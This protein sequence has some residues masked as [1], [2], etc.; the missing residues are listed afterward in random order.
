MPINEFNSLLTERRIQKVIKY[1]ADKFERLIWQWDWIKNRI[2]GEYEIKN[3]VPLCPNVNC[4]NNPLKFSME[5]NI[6]YYYHCD[7]CK[8]SQ[9]IAFT[10]QIIEDQI[11]KRIVLKF[12]FP[13]VY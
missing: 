2:I 1:K 3:I 6:K 5:S 7:K 10:T 13:L 8:T 9:G 12:G 11:Q 4:D